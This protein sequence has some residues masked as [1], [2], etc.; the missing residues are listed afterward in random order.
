MIKKILGILLCSSMLS[1][2][3]PGTVMATGNTVEFDSDNVAWIE[4]S[5][6]D[7]YTNAADGVLSTRV[8]INGTPQ[9]LAD[10]MSGKDAYWAWWSGA[11]Y[12]AAYKVNATT[13]GTYKLWYRGSDPT[14]SYSDKIVIEV[15]NAPITVSK[16]SGTDFTA[17]IDPSG[18]KK[19]FA[20]AWFVAEISLV[21]GENTIEYSVTE[22]STSGQK[23]AC[24]F[25]CMVLAPSTYKWEIPTVS[26]KPTEAKINAVEF[27]S[28]NVAW[29]E[30]CDYDTHSNS[31]DGVLSTRVGKNGTAQETADMMSGSDAYWAWW[32][33]AT[34]AATYN[35]KAPKTGKYK[36][37]YRGADPSIQYH[38]T[39]KIEVNDV[40]VTV[41]KVEGTDFVAKVDPSGTPKNF[42]CGWFWVEVNLTE[43][44]NKIE[45][46]VNEKSS[47][48]KYA[49]LFDCMVI[50]P[51]TYIWETPTIDTFPQKP[52]R[53]LDFLIDGSLNVGEKDINLTVY[54]N[55]GAPDMDAMVIPT[56]YNADGIIKCIEVFSKSFTAQDN[57]I[58]ISMTSTE[59]VAEGD[60]LKVFVWDNFK[61]M[62]PLSPRLTLGEKLYLAPWENS[63]FH[64]DLMEEYLDDEYANV[65]NYTHIESYVDRPNPIKFKWSWTG[66]DEVPT[67][68][69]LS[70]S[71]SPEMTNAKEYTTSG[72]FYEIL[73][74]KSGTNYYWTV[75]AVDSEGNDI[76]SG[77]A[78]S[79][80]SDKAPRN[81]FVHGVR[82][83]RDIGGWTTID[84]MVV[85]QGLLY[86]SGQLDSITQTGIK[87]LHDDLKIK[88]EIDFRRDGETRVYGD[89]TPIGDDV[90]Y[91]RYPLEYGDYLT[92]N[93]EAIKNIF[94]VL[95]DESNYPVIYHCAAGADRT[96]VITYLI[97]GL[98]GVPQE[99]LFRDF[100]LTNFSGQDRDMSYI[101]G[102]YV[103]I[104]DNYDNGQGTL[105][106]RI[107]K[108]LNNEIGVPAEQLDFVIEFLK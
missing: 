58:D 104:L 65:A 13:A 6:Y 7:T 21:G 68:Y 82:N 67:E 45:Y 39:I 22:K 46:Y 102:Q 62:T 53:L 14:N 37:W 32:S 96:G 2:M 94:N 43:G 105:Q 3:L 106:E 81:I 101:E 60:L 59:A 33:G 97:N 86:R 92:L 88:T 89:D 15:N 19:N 42:T 74:L 48:G 73:N 69:K 98:L 93:V 103:K 83:V 85:K 34:Y 51:A 24:L 87:I 52:E 20:C 64:K 8:G 26:T 27:D 55:E 76:I 77:V 23:Y 84:G 30:E 70:V 54:L 16:V 41:T 57:M 1:Y 17:T 95:S 61:N 12:N 71:E 5:D 29:I 90:Q 99:D 11:T 38:D 78:I 63:S 56:L 4:E 10:S 40:P 79:R 108:Y 50:S 18:T 75:S 66:T 80:T 47:K 107:Y 28:N 44:V 35:V 31:A 9:S 25:D 91:F 49:C 100:L 72:P 36:I